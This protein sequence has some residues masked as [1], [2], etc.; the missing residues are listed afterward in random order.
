M[1]TIDYRITGV[2]PQMTGN[3]VISE[4]S[5]PVLLVDPDNKFDY[6][7]QRKLAGKILIA[8]EHWEKKP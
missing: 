6:I 3:F 7:D 5:K 1:Y 8:L 4:D 2:A